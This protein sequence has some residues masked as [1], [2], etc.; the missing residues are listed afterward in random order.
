MTDEE[1]AAALRRMNDFSNEELLAA[2]LRIRPTKLIMMPFSTP[3]DVAAGTAILRSQPTVGGN[4]IEG[5]PPMMT[6]YT[7]PEGEMG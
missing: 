7:P 1:F 4:V 3:E 2:H 5:S 6:I